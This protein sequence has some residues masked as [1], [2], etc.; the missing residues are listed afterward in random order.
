MLSI[1]YGISDELISWPLQCVLGS[2]VISWPALHKWGGTHRLVFEE[3]NHKRK[4]HKILFLTYAFPNVGLPLEAFLPDTLDAQP[5]P[6]K[7]NVSKERCRS[8][9][10]TWSHETEWGDAQG[11][12]TSAAWELEGGQK[13]SGVLRKATQSRIYRILHAVEAYHGSSSGSQARPKH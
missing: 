8:V 9:S 10:L 7:G 3:T 6:P 11:S 12:H 5:L 13:T 1:H 2:A 4:L